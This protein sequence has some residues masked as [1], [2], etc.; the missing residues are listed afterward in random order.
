MTG[1]SPMQYTRLEGVKA[2]KELILAGSNVDKAAASM[3]FKTQFHLTR[4]FSA[5]E[6]KPP[7]FF[8]K[9]ARTKSR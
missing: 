8:R 2:A 1:L 9:L 6:G 3:G 5:V 7:I 4:I